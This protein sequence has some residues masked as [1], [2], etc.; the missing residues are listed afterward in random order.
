MQTE[1]ISKI[2]ASSGGDVDNPS[3]PLQFNVTLSPP[4]VLPPHTFMSVDKVKYDL[5]DIE[6]EVQPP[7]AIGATQIYLGVEGLGGAFCGI[8]LVAPPNTNAM[9]GSNIFN[10]KHAGIIYLDDS[11]S[12]FVNSTFNTDAGMFSLNNNKEVIISELKFQL[13][14]NDGSPL[15]M[16]DFTNFTEINQTKVQLSF[17]K[18]TDLA[19]TIK[20]LMQT[21]I[22]QNQKAIED[23]NTDPENIDKINHN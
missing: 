14:G 2:V 13:Y 3:S 21:L 17:H 7:Q 4:L 9:L 22:S 16:S 5:F 23:N 12:N 11:A 6:G 19:K 10:T 18:K 1:M 8:R 20:N 15:H